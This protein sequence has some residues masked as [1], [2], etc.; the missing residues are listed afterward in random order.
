M[1]SIFKD[2][3]ESGS[4]KA[5]FKYIKVQGTEN[6]GISPLMLNGGLHTEPEKL[7]KILVDQLSFVFTRDDKT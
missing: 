6:V 7:A 5:F 2:D 4:N 3:L 1:N